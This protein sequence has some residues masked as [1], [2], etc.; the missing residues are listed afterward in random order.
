MAIAGLALALMVGAYAPSIFQRP[1][2]EV[3]EGPG[4]W[5]FP[6]WQK[7]VG[8]ARSA[9]DKSARRIAEVNRRLSSR[10]Q[11]LVVLVTPMKA[12]VLPDRL[13]KQRAAFEESADYRAWIDE[14]RARGV[15]VADA[16]PTLRQPSQTGEASYPVHDDHWSAE[17]AERVA[18]D[19]AAIVRAQGWT[20]A[21]GGRGQALGAWTVERRET[22][23]VRQ[24]RQ[25]G[26]L[27]FGEEAFPA[28]EYTAP[29]AGPASIVLVGNSFSGTTYG[30][31]R[32]LSA[33][34]D[35][36]AELLVEF[37]IDG[38]WKAM[39]HALRQ[40]WPRETLVVWQIGEDSL[41][42]PAAGAVLDALIGHTEPRRVAPA[43]QGT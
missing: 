3:L 20:P 12:R 34:L 38:P 8:E 26:D 13:P 17:A 33:E 1:R 7:R 36:K 6:G 9:A 42:D 43:G 31:G 40:D 24:L 18:V 39:A 21:F 32:R 41:T 22:G 30:L 16:L 15:V 23:L 29:A 37:D 11:R 19:L 10:G 5:L 4:G 35:R 2:P 28:R 25:K 14:L 27:R